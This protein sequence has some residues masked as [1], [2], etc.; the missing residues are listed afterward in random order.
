MNSGYHASKGLGAHCRRSP[1][2]VPRTVLYTYPLAKEYAEYLEM[3][4][5]AMVI[6][7]KVI[8][9]TPKVISSTFADPWK[10]VSVS[11][12]EIADLKAMHYDGF[13]FGKTL[14]NIAPYREISNTNPFDTDTCVLKNQLQSRKPGEGI[15]IDVATGPYGQREF[16]YLYLID[17]EGMHIIREMIPCTVSSRGVPLHSLIKYRGVIGGEIFFDDQNPRVAYVNFGSARLTFRNSGEAE[18]AA[19]FI[20]SLGYDKIVAV[21]SDRDFS[22]APYGMKDR[23][24][25]SLANA[26]FVREGL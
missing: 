15:F 17:F 12:R 11:E 10:M 6:D 19:K 7:P 14:Y 24:G 1:H 25:E 26:V 20:L 13:E 4:K 18:N 22:A 16:K 23:Y 2:M 21:Y 8:A 5:K 9:S 3:K